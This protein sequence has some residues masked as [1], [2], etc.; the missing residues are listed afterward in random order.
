MNYL[1]HLF[2]VS[3]LGLTVCFAQA[4]AVVQ[5]ELL[6]IGGGAS[7]TTAGI[8]ASRMGVQTLII[9]E[10]AWLGGMLTAA[11]V[12]AIDGNHQLPSGLWGEFRNKLYTYYGGPAAVETGWVSN[13]LFEPSVGN[14]LLKELANQDQLEIWYEAQWVKVDRIDNLWQVSVKKGNKNYTI[15]AK[16]L[17]DA[18]ELGDVMAATG[19]AYSIGMD[20]RGY[21]R[22]LCART[23]QQHYPRPDLCCCTKRFWCR[24]R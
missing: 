7:G 15:Q 11:G 20:S 10:T 9:E 23:S 4:Q 12:S 18:T 19:A 16:V 24:C 1:K 13:T 17:I 5:T 21:R 3:V 8:Q 14:K 22:K 6:I 2:L